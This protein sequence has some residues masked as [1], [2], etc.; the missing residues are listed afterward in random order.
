VQLAAFDVH[1]EEAARGGIPAR[2]FREFRVRTY[3]DF[4][5]VRFS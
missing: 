3:G 4:H 1:P 5:G 2:A